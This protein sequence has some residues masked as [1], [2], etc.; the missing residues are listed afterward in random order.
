MSNYLL[1]LNLY[2][3]KCC[4]DDYSLFAVCISTSFWFLND[5]DMECSHVAFSPFMSAVVHERTWPVWGKIQSPVLNFTCTVN[6]NNT[7][8][9]TSPCEINLGK[10]LNTYKLKNKIKYSICQ[11]FPKMYFFENV[12]VLSIKVYAL[13]LTDIYWNL[14]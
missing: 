7:A 12:C 8:K 9:K 10:K 2:F 6:L 4:N 13:I 3:Q 1:N 11:G 5:S 14:Q